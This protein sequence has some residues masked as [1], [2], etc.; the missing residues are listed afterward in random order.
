LNELKFLEKYSG[1]SVDE[2]IELESEYRI[3]SL[4]LA[5]EEALYEKAENIGTD[6]LTDIEKIILA[7][8]GLEREVNNG[9][10]HQFFVNASVEFAPIIV[11]SLEAIGCPKTAGITSNAIDALGISK[12]VTIEKIEEV[13]YDEDEERDEKLDECDG[14]YFEYE[15]PIA[16][17]LFTFIKM[18]K[19][20][21]A[22]QK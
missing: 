19:D 16:D 11:D 9:G 12:P 17:R 7:I 10:Y 14:L 15:E 6:K 2:I 13:I 8:E 22:L 3:D 4:V 20:K 21:I 18:N 1:Q 5:I